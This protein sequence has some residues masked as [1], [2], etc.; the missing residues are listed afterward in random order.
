MGGSELTPRRAGLLQHA[1]DS[2]VAKRGLP[3]SGAHRD[4]RSRQLADASLPTHHALARVVAARLASLPQLR[5]VDSTE[6]LVRPVDRTEA[7]RHG[8]PEGTAIPA[9]IRTVVAR[10]LAATP[11]ILVERGVVPSAEVLAELVPRIAGTTVAASYGDERLRTLMGANYEAFRNRRSLLLLDLEHQ[12][13][14]DELPWVQAVSAF[15]AGGAGAV[16]EARGALVRLT[17]LALDAFPATIVPSPLVTEL[18]ALA[19]EAGLSLPL[20][21]ELA[22]DI[23]MGTFSAKFV[24]AAKLAGEL[25]RGSVYERYFGVDY[26][27]VLAIDDVGRKNERSA[28]TSAAFD[29]Y[30]AAR[31]GGPSNIWSAAA[32]GTIIEQAQILTTHNLAALTGPFGVGEALGIDWPSAARKSFERELAL[33]GRLRGNPRPLRM[34]KDLAYGWRQTVFFVAPMSAADADGFVTWARARVDEQPA[35]VA[36]V[37]TPVLGGLRDVMDGAGFDQDG[38][39]ENGRRLLGWTVGRHWV[40]D[41]LGAARPDA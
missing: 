28:P 23:F 10:T 22:A 21:E 36:A 5:G 29:A 37:M 20:V 35:H 3:E 15:R 14:V 39:S 32:N 9:S 8:V 16:A 4:L 19:R 17:E 33:A 12:V 2:M 7:A 13:R 27:R 34:I 30:C 25:L 1:V 40:L 26:E 38:R 41:A 24:E 11:E 31:A 18:D 6:P